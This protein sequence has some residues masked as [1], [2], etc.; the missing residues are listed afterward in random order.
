MKIAFYTLGCKLNQSESEALASGFGSRGFSVINAHESAD[1]YVVSTCTVT[2]KAEQKARRMIRK[3]SRENPLAVI[4][5]TGCYVQLDRDLLENIVDN[6]FLV[7][8]DHK[9]LLLY[10]PEYLASYGG[11][12]VKAGEAEAPTGLKDVVA[13]F[14]RQ[15]SEEAPEHDPFAFKADTFEYHSR[16]FLKIQDGCDNHCAYCRVTLARGES[17]SLPLTDV[18]ERVALLEEEGYRE[19]VLTGINLTSWREPVKVSESENSGGSEGYRLNFTDMLSRVLEQ[20]QNTR[21]RLSSL[22]P[23][24]I[25]ESLAAVLSHPNLCPHFHISVQSGSNAV[26]KMMR[27]KNNREKIIKGVELLREACDNPY[28]AADVIVGFPGE[29]EADFNESYTLMDSLQFSELHVFPFSP[30]PGTAALDMKNP[31]PERVTGERTSR[32]RGLSHRLHD[33]YLKSCED[34]TF[35]FILEQPVEKFGTQ[36]GDDRTE[37]WVGSDTPPEIWYATS[38][39]YLKL[40]V[41]F[42]SGNIE[43]SNPPEKGQI[44][45]AKVLSDPEKGYYAQPTT[46]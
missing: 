22:E 30:R 41:K 27:R 9:D 5:I 20:V 11:I 31:V 13:A 37:K 25:T 36:D 17:F 34:K 2:S 23:E 16:A 40:V 28:I 15:M 4:I 45:R 39:N 33:E 44:V 38:G 7:S 6:T 12:S 46:D 32:M 3:F 18:L 10:L 43:P 21:I 29:T 1:I 35:D 19:I 8:Q 14:F 26:L 42:S 24:T